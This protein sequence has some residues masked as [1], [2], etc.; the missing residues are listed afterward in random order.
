MTRCN[1]PKCNGTHFELVELKVAKSNYIYQAIQCSSCQR[2]VAVVE[3]HYLSVML[4]SI[5]KHLGIQI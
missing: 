4:Q 5:M 3:T 2:A 1:D